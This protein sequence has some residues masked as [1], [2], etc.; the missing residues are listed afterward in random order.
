[1]KI[2][3]ASKSR[4][5]GREFWA[6][7][8]RH[9]GRIDPNTNELGRRVRRGL[10]TP[11]EYEADRLVEQLNE[12]LASQPMWGPAAR[13]I[14]AM[15]YD[16]RV[17]EIFY[18]GLESTRTDFSGIRDSILRLPT[19]DEG[20]PRVL[21][22]G[23]TGAGKTT[24]VRQLLGTD[25]STERFPSTSTAK[26]TI[27][28]TELIIGGSSEFSAVVTFSTHDEIVDSLSENVV[29][30]AIAVFNGK[31]DEEVQRKLLDHLNQRHRFS[32]ILGRGVAATGVED[33]D[34]DDDEDEPSDVVDDSVFD[35]I[36]MAATAVVLRECTDKLKSIVGKRTE[37]VRA[38]LEPSSDDERTITELIE[39]EIQ[40][41]LHEAPEFHQIVDKLMD[42]ME[43][44]FDHLDA[45]QL[46][47]NRQGWPVSWHWSTGD[48]ASFI[49]TIMR[50]SS[51]QASL[52]GTLLTPLV[53]GIRVAGPFKPTWTT[54]T[55]TLVLIDGEGLGHTPGSA[56]TLSTSVAKQVE[57]VD[58]VVLV[59]NAQQPMQAAPLAAMKSLAVSGNAKKL[60]LLF[61][62]F[63][64][65]KGQNMP[66]FTQKEEHVLASAENVL[67][68]LGNELGPVGER[69]LRKRL[70]TARYFVG[71]IHERLDGEKKSQ[72]RTRA[73]LDALLLSIQ[74]GTPV[75]ATGLG[76]PIYDRMHLSIAVSEAAQAFH[77]KW[78]AL[79]GLKAQAEN[80]KEPWQRIKA[81][82]RRL[83]S[84]MDD[85]YDTLMP[86]ADL[87]NQLQTQVFVM[88]QRPVSW[89]SSEPSEDEKQAVIENASNAVTKRLF[90]LTE[91][92]LVT[93]VQPAWSDAY[94]LSGAGSTFERA[95]RIANDVYDRAVPVPTAAA[96]LD[97]NK[98]LTEIADLLT[99][100]SEEVGFE[101]R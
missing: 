61:T 63:D 77:R 2:Y 74:Q 31:S 84:G 91:R 90:A 7:I 59:D 97:Q 78:R 88:L 3:T 26:T 29:E 46:K 71:N 53:N 52:F 94:L 66:S 83:A 35:G 37:Y 25:P 15:K 75:L 19:L 28:E 93:D 57:S 14:A 62:H 56:S 64:L 101:F 86:V 42:E 67:S 92:R 11:N 72:K 39:D 1:M 8:F 6:V 48:R 30:A 50:F 10:G 100:V 55:P 82:T 16:E 12:L 5:K 81:L 65:V 9:P 33:D 22:L 24:V 96:T 20:Y 69:A 76:K 44:R 70:E 51:N 58:A 79:L 18:D 36:D 85:H 32:Y 43:L 21:L 54:D 60:H 45:H 27:A 95:R 40:N 41:Q 23:T 80:P 99:E 47:R 17:V 89:V 98:F 4:S 87:R 68:S 38:Q 49:K 73:Q 13:S 34:Y